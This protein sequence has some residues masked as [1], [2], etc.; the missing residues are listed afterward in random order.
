VKRNRPEIQQVLVR[1]RR[2]IRRYVLLQGISVT[3][4]LACL[5]FW[6]TFGLDLA[7]F[8]LSRME[9]PGWFRLFCTLAMGTLLVATAISWAG[10]RLLRKMQ[11]ADL[12]LALERKFPSL[13]D[14]LITA[15]ELENHGGSDIQSSM[16]ERTIDEAVS[17]LSGVQLRETI[18]PMPLRRALT[19]ASVLAASVLILGIADAQGMERWYQAYIL[20]R[21]DYWEPYRRNSLKIY[22]LAPPGERERHFDAHGVYRHPRGADLQLVALVPE[23]AV[24]P[25]RVDL[26][27]ISHAGSGQQRGQLT[28]SRMGDSEFRHT[29][30]R[31]VNDQELWFRGGDFVT[32]TPLRVQVVDPPRVEAIELDCDFP[33]YIDMEDRTLRVVGTQIE[34]PMETQFV[35]GADAN[36]PLVRVTM[37]CQPMELSIAFH[38]DHRTMSLPTRLTLTNSE[39]GTLRSVELPESA[40]TFFDAGRRR[41][42]IPMKITSAA[43]SLLADPDYQPSFPLP[44]PPDETLQ[45]FLEDEDQ[46]YSPEPA[47][48]TISGIVDQPPVVDTR[49]TGI[50]TVVTRMATIPI[51]GRLTDDYGLASAWFDYRL[52]QKPEDQKLPLARQP[53]GQK[54]F[55]LQQSPE[56]PVEYFNL[57]PLQLEE[58]QTI[59]LSVYAADAD[60]LN[61]PHIAHGELFTFKIVSKDELLARLFDREVTLRAR[62]EQI[63][64]EVDELRTNLEQTQQQISE[65]VSKT[66]KNTSDWNVV[67]AY[68]DRGLHQI[69]KNHTES[70]SIEVSFRDLREEMVNNHIDTAELLER[71]ERRIIEP[72]S[73]L[74]AADFLEVDRR[75]GTLRLTIERNGPSEAAAGEVVPAVSHLIDQMDQILA[76]MRDRGTINDLIQNL[77]DIIKRQ[78]QQLE[79]TEDKRIEDSFFSPLK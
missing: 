42:N 14:R 45:I 2:W 44:L 28:L 79:Q 39:T 54:E 3:L 33:D 58:G 73:L 6:L 51:E 75:F 40:A 41:F 64:S 17:R 48:L 71:I 61:G 11:P 70:R 20:G 30:L 1:L 59:A 56:V 57:I 65:L 23:E 52:G 50:G 15:V 36:K 55:R 46:I 5:M 60:N 67:M 34:V 69:R 27:Y 4:A 74:N 24:P 47:S 72:M 31:V 38:A 22:V 77:Q 63:R 29:L 19:V 32:R 13:N 37:R 53:A 68:V 10:T 35:L 49:R 25:Q 26:Q 43:A 7:Y 18:N 16:L 76:E 78:K 66:G 62:F 21:D 8:H 9:L 12:A